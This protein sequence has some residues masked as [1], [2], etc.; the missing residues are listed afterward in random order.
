MPNLRYLILFIFFL[1]TREVSAQA[2]LRVL[3][4]QGEIQR[5][6]D[7]SPLK[8][9]DELSLQTSVFLN[10]DSCQLICWNKQSGDLWTLQEPKAY[11][12]K[13]LAQALD[14][15][16]VPLYRCCMSPFAQFRYYTQKPYPIFRSQLVFPLDQQHDFILTKHTQNNTDKQNLLLYEFTS[17]YTRDELNHKKAYVKLNADTLLIQLPARL[18]QKY[19]GDTYRREIDL[20]VFRKEESGSN[21]EKN[22]QHI[23]ERDICFVNPQLLAQQSSYL[24]QLLRTAHLSEEQKITRL[25]EFI[26]ALHGYPDAYNLSLWMEEYFPEK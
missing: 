7:Q 4:L 26:Y 2:V 6:S 8:I 22:L 15:L 23:L 14:A 24:M 20:Y 13:V 9:G 12:V 16:E 1:Y 17:A 3:Y 25:S 10:G 19:S 5:A 18:I 21:S 11:Q